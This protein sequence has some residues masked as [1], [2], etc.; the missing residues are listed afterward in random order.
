MKKIILL[1]IIPF[2]ALMAIDF[3]MT[4]EGLI[5]PSSIDNS[6][7]D[8]TA[9]S[10]D[11]ATSNDTTTSS[12]STTSNDTATSSDS[13][14]SNDTATS[15]DNATSNDTSSDNATSNDTSSTN[16][17]LEPVN[18]PKCDAS[19]PEVQFIRSNADWNK[20][21]SSSKRIF[22]VSPGDYT[23]LGSIKLTANGTAKKRRYILLNNGN[24][25]H[26]AKLDSSQLAN[27]A[28]KFNGASYWTLD[29]MARFDV[30]INYAYS[31]M[32][33]SSYNILNRMYT[34]N[35]GQS[36]L[37]QNN[38]HNNT[39]QNSRFNYMTHAKRKGDGVCISLFTYG[40]Q[41]VTIKNTKIINNEIVNQGDGIQTVRHNRNSDGKLQDANYEGTIID[42]NDIYIT[43][44]IYTD[45]KGN[46]TPTGKYAYAE[47]AIDLKVGSDN[48]ANPIVITNNNMWGS[49][50]SDGTNSSISSGGGEIVVHYGVKNVIINDNVM[51]NASS[52][53]ASG[54]NNRFQYSMSDSEI[55]RNIFYDLGTI[56][57]VKYPLFFAD[58]N[59]DIV[60][61]DN[62][63]KDCRSHQGY[64][65]RCLRFNYTKN[66][67]I[68]QK[69]A[70]IY[71]NPEK[72]NVN[73]VFTPKSNYTTVEGISEGYTEDYVFT[74]DNFTNSP[75]VI[76]L[77][78][79]LKAN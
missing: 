3:T 57:D 60:I 76:S 36:V 43:S 18:L 75:R 65:I 74:T 37:V 34:D 54:D 56:T 11:S 71:T 9:T 66:V 4:R 41:M 17:Y 61:Q 47:D 33:G 27:M 73:S 48:P 44:D 35:I 2:V 26:P 72:R 62:V 15:S 64:F 1:L 68:N 20:I 23:S 5:A 29:R 63:T 13:T 51:F 58:L 55:K 78:N 19:N 69:Y 49:R 32:N 42:S 38:C 50:K 39:I 28:I 53:I 79:V 30:D 6:S 14:T 52:G 25:T 21:N 24:D 16:P 67:I 77:K 45:G 46:Y 31:F 7:T 22:C 70:G 59:A 40:D 8:T 10:S 12:D